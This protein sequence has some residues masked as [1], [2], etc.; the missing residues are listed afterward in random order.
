MGLLT[1]GRAEFLEFFF[2]VLSCLLKYNR[3]HS[4][5]L[6]GAM[7]YECGQSCPALPTL[8]QFILVVPVQGH[9]HS[10]KYP[11]CGDELHTHPNHKGIK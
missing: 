4:P 1:K 7:C 11:N 2:L 6:D 8:S 5:D 10:Q 3:Y 9:F